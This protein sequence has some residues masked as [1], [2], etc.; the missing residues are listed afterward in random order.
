MRFAALALLLA[1][2]PALG[3][4]PRFEVHL[5]GLFAWGDLDFS[6]TRQFRLLGR[7]VPV[8]AA[9]EMDSA[10]GF[11]LGL[12]LN[13]AGPFGLRASVSRAVHE[14]SG[15]LTLE[16]PPLLPGLP[17]Q[18]EAALPDGRVEETAVHVAAVLSL[19]T[20]PARISALGGVTF[21]DLEAR[22]LDSVEVSLP[23]RAPLSFAGSP[24][25]EVSDSPVGWNVGI[26]LDF[27]L[28]DAVALG[29]FLRYSRASAELEP[30]GGDP[31]EL[32]AGGAHA[33]L[34]LR[35]RF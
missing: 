29:G 7:N 19:E 35:L 28:S 26:G 18:V 8:T 15:R 4:E 24:S 25:L 6:E 17:R 14:G 22:L 32:D 33:G 10:L 1:A 11:D 9:Y 23:A 3:Q 21:F 16:L 12:Q 30:P 13:V 2:G 31:I 5:N 34:G 27:R 20:G